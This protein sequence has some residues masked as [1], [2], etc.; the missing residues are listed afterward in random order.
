MDA[1]TG[2]LVAAAV[3]WASVLA[4]IKVPF[5]RWLCQ[6]TLRAVGSLTL[7]LVSASLLGATVPAWLPPSFLG[8]GLLLS[9]VVARQRAR[10]PAAA[11]GRTGPR[12]D[13]RP[14]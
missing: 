3:G 5:Q 6:R 11:A 10:V 12:P 4:V 2:A 7:A 14:P 1:V 13:E 8:G 9:A